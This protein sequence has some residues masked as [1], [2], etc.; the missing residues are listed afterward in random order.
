VRTESFECQS[1]QG[2]EKKRPR[3][4]YHRVAGKRKGDGEKREGESKKVFHGKFEE[5]GKKKKGGS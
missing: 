1:D 3:C 4:L 2:R 5:K